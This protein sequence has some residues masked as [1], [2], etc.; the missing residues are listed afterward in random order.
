MR[1]ATRSGEGNPLDTNEAKASD[2]TS[3]GPSQKR[4]EDLKKKRKMGA[5]A[6]F[7]G[8]VF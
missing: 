6:F 5:S 7:T 1:M 4:N 8:V 3:D 2:W